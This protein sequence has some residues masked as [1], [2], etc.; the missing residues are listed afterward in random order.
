MRFNRNIYT[1]LWQIAVFMPIV[2]SKKNEHELAELDYALPKS[3]TRETCS[4]FE[5]LVLTAAMTGK[6][7]PTIYQTALL[8]SMQIS[9]FEEHMFKVCLH[10]FEKINTLFFPKED[11]Q[12]YIREGDKDFVKNKILLEQLSHE[13]YEMFRSVSSALYFYKKFSK[14]KD[15]YDHS[16]TINNAIDL[17]SFLT[18]VKTN[19]FEMFADRPVESSP[20]VARYLVYL[21]DLD[22][23]IKAS[24]QQ[25]S[26]D[27]RTNRD[28][29]FDL[30]FNLA[31]SYSSNSRIRDNPDK[32]EKQRRNSI[33]IAQN[34]R[35]SERQAQIKKCVKEITANSRSSKST[36]KTEC[37]EYFEKNKEKLKSINIT[38][39]RTLQNHCSN[40]EPNKQRSAFFNRTYLALDYSKDFKETIEKAY[41]K[42][43]LQ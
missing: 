22:Q 19:L 13:T 2:F 38:S 24:I 11:P 34:K 33:S 14:A 40:T 8:K 28:Y 43:D 30:C 21:S 12:R 37:Y 3:M 9:I 31:V 39:Y 29:L 23:L 4:E 42:I 17:Y 1:R 5:K 32:R 36:I 15:I 7:D 27:E 6:D 35:L 16:S 20:F 26:S 25:N 18:H 41:S 10:V